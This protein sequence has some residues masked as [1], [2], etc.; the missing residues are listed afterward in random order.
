MQRKR[1]EGVGKTIT[2]SGDDYQGAIGVCPDCGKLMQ[3]INIT[4][5]MEGT[6]PM[7]HTTVTLE[8]V[9]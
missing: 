1:C 6:L 4:D 3:L 2:M 7:H 8:L 9:H 5:R